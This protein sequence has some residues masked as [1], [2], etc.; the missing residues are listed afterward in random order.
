MILNNTNIIGSGGG[1][2]CVDFDKFKS[3]TEDILTKEPW[4]PDDNLKRIARLM[5]RT[6]KDHYEL[7]SSGL[8]TWYTM[9]DNETLSIQLT[10][11]QKSP[12]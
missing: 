3:L 6:G 5:Q 9:P 7:H 10:H 2:V 4:S 1:G 12:A 8:H 11:P